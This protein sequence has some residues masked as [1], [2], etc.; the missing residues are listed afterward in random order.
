VS[1]ISNDSTINYLLLRI[2]K[3][4]TSVR[5]SMVVSKGVT[6]TNKLEYNDT[7][8]NKLKSK[9]II[10]VSILI[11][12]STHYESRRHAP[13]FCT[14]P[15]SALMWDT[16]VSIGNCTFQFNNVRDVVFYDVQNIHVTQP[17]ACKSKTFN[18]SI[19]SWK[20][21]SSKLRNC[22]HHVKEGLIVTIE[23]YHTCV[24]NFYIMPVTVVYLWHKKPNVSS[25]CQIYS[26]DWSLLIFPL[27]RS[28]ALEKISSR[29]ILLASGVASSLFF[30]WNKGVN[31]L[32]AKLFLLIL[33]YFIRTI[34]VYKTI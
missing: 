23:K 20:V 5:Q 14:W 28:R 27:H 22:M 9:N 3:V 29:S 16:F 24:T 25:F 34:L 8:I 32:F 12:I 30:W 7:N 11:I 26:P 2:R 21:T 18:F 13:R 1:T 4:T 33:F 15:G 17:G 31:F 6:N 10:T 19:M